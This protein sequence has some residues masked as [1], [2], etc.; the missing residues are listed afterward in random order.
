MSS[1]KN[2]LRRGDIIYSCLFAMSTFDVSIHEVV[3]ELI[4]DTISLDAAAIGGVG[5]SSCRWR[6]VVGE[7]CFAVR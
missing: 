6:S 2:G 3:T 1:E 4:P 5:G 7:S